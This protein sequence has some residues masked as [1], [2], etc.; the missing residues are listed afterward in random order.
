MCLFKLN[1]LLL[2][3]LRG[4][5]VAKEAGDRDGYKATG[6]YKVWGK[7]GIRCDD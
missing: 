5:K 1:K 3:H 6:W 7:V 4:G 2:E